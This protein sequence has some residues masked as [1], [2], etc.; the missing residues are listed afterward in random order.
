[1]PCRKCCLSGVQIQVEGGKQELN[2]TRSPTSFHSLPQSEAATFVL[3]WSAMSLLC[4]LHS[5]RTT[6]SQMMSTNFR[7]LSTEKLSR[8]RFLHVNWGYIPAMLCETCSSTCLL[9]VTWSIRKGSTSG[10]ASSE[11]AKKL[12][13][14]P[15][16]RLLV[17]ILAEKF[18]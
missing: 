5:H 13:Q 6:I 4:S 17:K 16:I 8:C 12:C 10:T 7:L 9:N 18:L 3:F 14:D 2:Q 1:M 15:A 11:T